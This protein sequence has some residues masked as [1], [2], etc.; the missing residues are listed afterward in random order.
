LEWLGNAFD[1]AALTSTLPSREVFAAPRVQMIEGVASARICDWL[2][3]RARP[4]VAPALV[5]DHATGG[6]RS[7]QARTNS[8]VAFN[9]AQSDMILMLLRDRI[10]ASAGLP[11]SSLEAPAILHYAPGQGFEPHFDFLDSSIPAYARDMAAKGQRV[12]TFLL[13]LNDDYEGGE[14]DFPKLD[15][16]YKGRKGDALLFWN[17]APSGEPDRQTFHAGLPTTRGEK[18]LL[19]Q[20]LRQPARVT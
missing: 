18:W 12:A 6:S 20:W 5:Y 1:P 17:V 15:W 7:E 9:I 13:Y 2:I 4:R 3:E 8:S 14:T 11:L 19:S 16:R 10:A